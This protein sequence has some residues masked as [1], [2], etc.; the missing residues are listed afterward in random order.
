MRP[1]FASDRAH[2]FVRTAE[3]ETATSI[4]QESLQSGQNLFFLSFM[5]RY[6][7]QKGIVSTAQLTRA[8]R[9]SP[10]LSSLA[11]QLQSQGTFSAVKAQG[12]FQVART[13]DPLTPRLGLDVQER[14]VQL[15][16]PPKPH[17]AGTLKITVLLPLAATSLM[18]MS[19]ISVEIACSGTASYAIQS[20]SSC[21]PIRLWSIVVS[22]G[23]SRLSIPPITVGRPIALAKASSGGLGRTS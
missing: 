18:D 3:C 6:E 14:E 1:H 20:E 12:G 22:M 5:P 19:P 2:C 15:A 4:A 21:G 9:P 13:S 17:R 10:A 8:P 7:Q 11:H 16:F 23:G